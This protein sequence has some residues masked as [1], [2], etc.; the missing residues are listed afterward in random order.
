[1]QVTLLKLPSPTYLAWLGHFPP[2]SQAGR[3][4]GPVF[5]VYVFSLGLLE[6]QARHS[7][8]EVAH[9]GWLS[10]FTIQ[11]QLEIPSARSWAAPVR[12][13][14]MV[15]KRQALRPVHH[16]QNHTCRVTILQ[17]ARRA[18]VLVQP[19]MDLV[20]ILYRSIINKRVLTKYK[21]ITW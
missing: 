20:T 14:D 6:Y 7:M 8:R 11:Q 3:L 21:Q 1:M 17:S 5:Y 12:A 4:A 9:G 10:T 16:V 18:A 2:A 15:R 13:T 19:S